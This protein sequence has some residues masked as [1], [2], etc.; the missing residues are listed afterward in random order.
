MGKPFPHDQLEIRHACQLIFIAADRSSMSTAVHELRS[1]VMIRV[2]ATWEDERG[3]WHTVPAC[4]EDRSASGACIRMKTPIAVGSKLVIQ[5]RFD[6]FSGITK[7]CRS[8]GREFL[9]GIQRDKSV[10]PIGPVRPQAPL[11]ESAKGQ[12]SQVAAAKIQPQLERHENQ[13]TG[14]PVARPKTESKPVL[15]SVSRD[16]PPVRVGRENTGDR[17][18]V[19]RSREFDAPRRS[20]VRTKQP[21]KRKPAS[22]ERKSMKRKWLELAPWRHKQDVHITRSDEGNEATG[23]GTRNRKGRDASLAVNLTASR[24]K[25]PV[26]SQEEGGFQVELLPMEEIYAAAGVLTPRRGYSVAKVVDMLHSE[27]L[28]GVS[29]EMKRAAVLVALEA[30][31]ATI[32]QIQQDAKARRE[33]LDSYEK[34][35]LAQVEAE[36][37][38]KAEENTQIEAEL[39]RLKGQYMAR[40][41][42][43][44]EAVTRE[45]AAFD[46]W[47]RLKKQA[48]ENMAEAVE[49]C[50]MPAASEVVVAPLA[51]AT[52][53]AAASIASASS[54]PSKS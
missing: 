32:G 52:A 50:L 46:S 47:Q 26:D 28:R 13:P 33:V 38:R 30:A 24:E 9:V 6:R 2:E 16:T 7:Y 3:A 22:K 12:H 51:K 18:P 15:D 45:K 4:M 27:H 43:N 40:V 49:L 34:E 21:P 23:G 39:E 37:A 41:T 29:A 25:S 48:A 10:I 5:W 53:L 31:G 11:E 42:R 54:S 8:D 1:V 19:S 36:W 20:E 14:S 35:Q 17:L 44:L